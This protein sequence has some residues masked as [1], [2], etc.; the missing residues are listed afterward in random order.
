MK[1]R[2]T[3]TGEVRGQSR[4]RF[5]RFGTYKAKAD[6]DYERAICEAYINSGGKSF[7]SKPIY[8][9]IRAYRALPKSMPRYIEAEPDTHKPDGSNILKSVEDALNGIAYDDDRQIVDARV[10]KMPRTRC[11]ERLEIEVGLFYG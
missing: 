7:G 3:Y 2:F 11:C 8:I 5:S 9:E 10:I 6:K 4:P 1:H